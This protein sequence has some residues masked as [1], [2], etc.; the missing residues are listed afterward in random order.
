MSDQHLRFNPQ[1]LHYEVV[2]KAHS[3]WR[4]VIYVL[5]VGTAFGVVFSLVGANLIKS[6][7]VIKKEHDLDV[8]RDSYESMEKQYQENVSLLQKLEMQD[9][10]LFKEVFETEPVDTTFYSRQ[11]VLDAGQSGTKQDVNTLMEKAALSFIHI[12]K[13]GARESDHLKF[14][15]YLVQNNADFIHSLPIRVPLRKGIYTLVSGFGERIHPIFKTSQQHNGIDF[16]ARAGSEVLAAGDGIV[17]SP[18]GKLEGYGN[19]VYIYHGNG[20]YTLYA[21]L[22]ESKVKPGQKVKAGDVIGFVGATGITIGPHLHYEIR[23]DG[24]PIDPVKYL[25]NVPAK[26]HIEMIKVASQYNQCLS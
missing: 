1:T 4:D 7:D 10:K 12:E 18:P 16:A 11:L 20:Y 5:I 8:Y 19:V 14:M 21:Q 9:R 3:R 26:E 17:Q 25:L 22:L 24:K 6:K 13:L 2:K 23:R 15:Q